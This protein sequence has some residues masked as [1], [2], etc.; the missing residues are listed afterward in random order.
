MNSDAATH[1]E[2]AQI[3][4]LPNARSVKVVLDVT[5]Y[6]EDP[7]RQLAEAFAQAVFD[8]LH[9]DDGYLHGYEYSVDG[10]DIGGEA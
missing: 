3:A 7:D 4:A 8:L 5:L 6:A 1:G 9:T 2:D 10:W